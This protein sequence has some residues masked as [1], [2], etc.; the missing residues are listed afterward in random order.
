MVRTCACLQQVA[1]RL[2][3][4]EMESSFACSNFSAKM[5]FERWSSRDPSWLRRPMAMHHCAGMVTSI[6]PSANATFIALLC[7][8]G[9]RSISK[10]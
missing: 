8:R 3:R 4:T 5:K 1:V 7:S 6:C 10:K 2:Y 9:A